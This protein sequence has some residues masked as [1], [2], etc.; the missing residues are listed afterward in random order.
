MIRLWHPM[1]DPHHCSFRILTLLSCTDS[2]QIQL[3][4]LSFLDLFF[5]FPQYLRD[6]KVYS[7]AVERKRK[8]KLPKKKDSFVYIPDIRLVYRELQQYQKVA[9][10]RLVGRDI[11]SYEQYATQNAK[12]NSD[13]LPSEISSYIEKRAEA[14]GELL[15]FIVNDVGSLPIDGPN[16]LL[17]Q[18]GL[19]LGGRMR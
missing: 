18:T 16:S 13:V 4:K 15:S 14:D 9:M 6:V 17:R 5:L 10:D 11:L 19:E 7:E 2:K 1:R 12:L 8:L 3:A